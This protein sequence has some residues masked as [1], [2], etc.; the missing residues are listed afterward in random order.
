MTIRNALLV[1]SAV[2]TLAAPSVSPA[3]P[4]A[5]RPLRP[6][7]MPSSSEPRVALGRKLFFD[8]RLSSDGRLKSSR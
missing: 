2:A 6:E 8:A 5:L 7:G 4:Q 1:V 3:N